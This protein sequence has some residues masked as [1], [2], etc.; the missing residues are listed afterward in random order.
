MAK[1]KK[2]VDYGK[3]TPQL[4]NLVSSVIAS[5]KRHTYSASKV[6]AAHNAAFGLNDQ[7][8]TCSSCLRNRV[9]DLVRWLDG[10]NRYRASN[11][12]D[13]TTGD[14]TGQPDRES[15]KNQTE[16]IS[17]GVQGEPKDGVA[18]TQPPNDVASHILTNGD[19]IHFYPSDAATKGKVT[20]ADGSRIKPGTYSTAEG[21]EI[22][23]QPGGR[24]TI[25]EE[26][27]T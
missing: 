2:G 13:Q 19:E 24:A 5:A 12:D 10:Y 8:R 25:R 11:L 9:R 18:Y 23:V 1:T 3:V 22:A 7:P 17:T 27:L 15:P 14:T 21:L 20:Y 26:D 4:F 16:T 6:Y